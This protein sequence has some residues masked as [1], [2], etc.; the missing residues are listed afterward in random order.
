MWSEKLNGLLIIQVIIHG[1]KFNP[2]P[3]RIIGLIEYLNHAACKLVEIRII[4]TIRAPRY[5]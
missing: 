2:E 1:I 3:D 4:Y 5:K